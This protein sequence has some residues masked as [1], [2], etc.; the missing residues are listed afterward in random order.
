M[1]FA[2]GSLGPQTTNNV[3]GRL[4]LFNP[5]LVKM[6]HRTSAPDGRLRTESEFDDSHDSAALDHGAR[7]DVARLPGIASQLIGERMRAMYTTLIS[8]PVPDDLLELIRRLE[9]KERGE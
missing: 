9:S 2:T 8:E 3:V 4:A 1:A 5:W 6:Q 7:K